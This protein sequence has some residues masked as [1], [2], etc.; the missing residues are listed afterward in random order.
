MPSPDFMVVYVEIVDV[1]IPCLFKDQHDAVLLYM[2]IIIVNCFYYLCLLE[3]KDSSS[4]LWGW[5]VVFYLTASV[6]ALSLTLWALYMKDSVIPELNSPTHA[7][8][9]HS[10]SRLS[11]EEEL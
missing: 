6:S 7:L 2:A 1:F 8:T 11:S 3:M 10:A 4:I 9:T 5:R